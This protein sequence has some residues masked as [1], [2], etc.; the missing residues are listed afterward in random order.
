MHQWRLV[1]SRA[2][3]GPLAVVL[4]AT[5]SGCDAPP[6]PSGAVWPGHRY[7]HAVSRPASMSAGPTLGSHALVAQEQD[8]GSSPARTP[9]IDTLASGSWFLLFHGGYAANAAAPSDNFGNAWDALGAPVAYQGY[10]GTYDVKAWLAR[11]GRGGAGQVVSLPKVGVPAGELTMPF[12]ELRHVTRLADMAQ[13]Y[14]RAAPLVESG[15]V[16]TDGPA[17]LIALW[18]G[19][20][21]VLDNHADPEDGFEPVESVLALPPNSAVQCVVAWRR[22]DRA[23]RWRVGWKQRPK[24]GA[25]LWLLAFAGDAQ[26]GAGAPR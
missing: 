15:E 17:L 21:Y 4:L 10:D 11:S 5:V 26:A 14:A 23:G 19:D 24:Q 25:V 16:V 22:V 20:G 6:R 13:T 12:L 2:C 1:R 9:P 18:W 3:L 8:F 7:E